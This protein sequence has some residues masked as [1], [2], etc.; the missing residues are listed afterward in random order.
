MLEMS[1]A[2]TFCRT[3]LWYWWA[4]R[5]LYCMLL[6]SLLSS[7]WWMSFLPI[8]MHFAW[9]KSL[10]KRAMMHNRWQ[11]AVSPSFL[12]MISVTFAHC[13]RTNPC[14][15]R[16]WHHCWMKADY[17]W[18]VENRFVVSD[19]SA[20]WG[21]G[22]LLFHMFVGID[23][24]FLCYCCWIGCRYNWVGTSQCVKNLECLRKKVLSGDRSFVAL[25]EG[26]CCGGRTLPAQGDG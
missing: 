17:G 12:N 4:R 5:E 15:E 8:K 21:R 9:L 19:V 20:G 16:K 3:A 26:L 6:F 22:C 24:F 23:E 10:S 1:C 18:F 7:I 2:S 25:K 13:S 11:R 14:W